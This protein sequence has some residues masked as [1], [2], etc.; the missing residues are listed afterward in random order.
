MLLL[1]FLDWSMSLYVARGGIPER[2]ANSWK[3]IE[4]LKN[5]LPVEK[6]HWLSNLSLFLMN[7]VGILL[8]RGR[9]D[10]TNLPFSRPSN[11]SHPQQVSALQNIAHDPIKIL[12][13]CASASGQKRLMYLIRCI[14]MRGQSLT[15]KWPTIAPISESRGDI[16]QH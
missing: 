10:R 14:R 5:G 7:E 13:S 16:R 15:P 1:C 12:Y 4:R 6:H 9:L 2:Q 3:L 8:A 11:S